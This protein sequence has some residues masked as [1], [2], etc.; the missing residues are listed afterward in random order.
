M[1]IHQKI[2]S[3]LYIVQPEGRIDTHAMSEFAACLNRLIQQGAGKILINFSTT[4]YLSSPGLRAL[5]EAHREMSE[6][7]RVLAICSPEENLMELFRVVH[8]E[9][10]IN[11]YPTDFEAYEA[12]L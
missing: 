5:L 8:L 3:D 11:I 9:K 10:T 12:L 2:E 6:A 1:K 4:E 7:G